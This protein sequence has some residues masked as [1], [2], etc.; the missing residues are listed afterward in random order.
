M[1]KSYD[2]IIGRAKHQVLVSDSDIEKIKNGENGRLSFSISP[3]TTRQLFAA[4]K[5][6]KSMGCLL[7]TSPSPRDY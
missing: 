3:P 5:I 1:Y 2:L 4:K 7:Y 6:A